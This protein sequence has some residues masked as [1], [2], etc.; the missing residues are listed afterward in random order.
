MDDNSIKEIISILREQ[1]GISQ[2]EMASR[3]GVDRNTYR[4]LEKGDTRLLSPHLESIA[5]ELGTSPE[6]L[7]LGV[8][9]PGQNPFL[10]N[11]GKEAADKRLR[12]IELLYS[13]KIIALEKEIADLR[14]M[15]SILKEQVKDKEDIIAMLRKNH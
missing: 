2:T 3:I 4:N 10:V 14:S 11:E 6:R 7:I 13:D 1:K 9:L 8:E 12:K 15:V 5:R